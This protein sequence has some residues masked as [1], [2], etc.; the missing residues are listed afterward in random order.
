MDQLVDQYFD[1]IE[2]EDTNFVAV[3]D[4]VSD[5]AYLLLN[6]PTNMLREY[7]ELK[8]QGERWPDGAEFWKVTGLGRRLRNS[9]KYYGQ[10]HAPLNDILDYLEGEVQG[11]YQ[12]LLTTE[13]IRL[14]IIE[15]IEFDG[16]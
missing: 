6:L 7:Q 14:G 1:Q 3:N 12:E 11:D 15:I 2:I 16:D 10:G 8:G 9:E 5:G 13:R 4:A